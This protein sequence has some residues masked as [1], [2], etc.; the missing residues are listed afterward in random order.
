[1]PLGLSQALNRVRGWFSIEI[2]SAD[3][4]ASS[5][6]R[7]QVDTSVTAVTATLPAAPVVGD[8][9]IFEDAKAS[10]NTRNLTL[11]RN[12]LKINGATSNYVSS[13]N[14]AKLSVVYISSAYGWS[15]K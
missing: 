4:T 1:M 7:Y 10:F 3:F 2:K 9:I 14:N 8:E 6:R 11:N 13:T 12:S 15:V 5:G